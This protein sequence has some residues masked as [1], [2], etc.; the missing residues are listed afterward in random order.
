METHT[1]ELSETA[2]QSPLDSSIC[3]SPPFISCSPSHTGRSNV[4][5]VCEAVG[6]PPTNRSRTKEQLH[7]DAVTLS[8][9]LLSFPLC[10]NMEV[11]LDVGVDLCLFISHHTTVPFLSVNTHLSAHS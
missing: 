7:E 11:G 2:L 8:S 6:C 9:S 5:Q 10:E 3:P 4:D 1:W